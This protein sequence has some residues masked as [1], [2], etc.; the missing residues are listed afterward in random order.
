MR[1]DERRAV[2]RLDDLRHRERLARARDAEEDLLLPPLAES[3]DELLDRARLV[4]LRR[5]R[6]EDLEIRHEAISREPEAAPRRTS[7]AMT[8]REWISS[9]VTRPS[10]SA[11]VDLRLPRLHGGGLRRAGLRALGE[12]GERRPEALLLRRGDLGRRG[13]DDLV[14]DLLEGEAHELLRVREDEEHPDDQDDGRSGA[15]DE[16][17]LQAAVAARAPRLVLERQRRGELRDLRRRAGR[18]EVFG[19]AFL[20][21]A[22]RYHALCACENGP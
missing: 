5:E 17:P 14:A 4:A 9:P 2:Q 8:V 11:P 19:H 18:D 20:R 3:R 22:G 21:E 15:A 6:G 12:R 16:A 13:R 7:R 10:A 1:E